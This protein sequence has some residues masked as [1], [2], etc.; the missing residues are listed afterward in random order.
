MFAALLGVWKANGAALLV[1]ADNSPAETISALKQSITEIDDLETAILPEFKSCIAGYIPG[2]KR[3]S[4][5]QELTLARPD[6]LLQFIQWY[7]TTFSI[8]PTD[9]F[10]L[11]SSIN[12]ARLLWD[13]CIPLSLGATIHIPEDDALAG[14]AIAEWMRAQH[15]SV[16]HVTPSVGDMLL[17]ATEDTSEDLRSVCFWGN[18]LSGNIVRRMKKF[19][20]HARISNFYGMPEM[21]HPLT[22][23]T[24]E[25]AD[26]CTNFNPALL[27]TPVGGVELSIFNKEGIVCGIGEVGEVFARLPHLGNAEQSTGD[28]A[29]YRHDGNIEL[30]GRSNRTIEVRGMSIDL[31]ELEARLTQQNDVA[32]AV[33]VAQ[34]DATEVPRL[35]AYVVLDPREKA[36]ANDI[37]ARLKSVSADRL[38]PDAVTVLDEFPLTPD[39]LVD[40]SS[41]PAANFSRI[42]DSREAKT[43]QQTVLT[44]LFQEVLSVENV[45][46]ADDFFD[47]GGHSLLVSWLRNRIRTVLGV[48]VSVR[49]VFE[50][51]TVFQL[52]AKLQA[53]AG[54]G[55]I[56]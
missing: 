29:R 10:A 48:E 21:S 12:Y 41:L 2:M 20:P 53:R 45:G 42:P 3:S 30:V 16:M 15:V 54:A 34:R 18:R 52:S 25:S 32:Q 43:A 19:A 31:H 28:S 17:K 35:I 51:P 50:A 6:T 5:R 49:D 24:V 44:E 56:Q 8:G 47:L 13:V 22:C 37:L 46:L 9:R 23:Y 38:M 40:L 11:L 36:D 27:G 55:Q 33:V 26:D 1:S 39:G 14:N 7:S 4:Q